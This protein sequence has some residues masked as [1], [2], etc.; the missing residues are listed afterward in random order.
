MN[1][2]LYKLLLYFNK[3]QYWRRIEQPKFAITTQLGSYFNMSFKDRLYDNHYDLF[4]EKGYPIRK[5]KKG[6]TVYNYTTLCSYALANWQEYLETGD[7]KFLN[8]L[9]LVVD[10]L[11]NNHETTDYGGVI[12]TMGGRT[13]AMS[14]GEALAVIA[15]AYE[16]RP[17]K[18]LIE[19]ARKIIRPFEVFVPDRGVKGYFK[20]VDT[21]WYEENTTLPYKHILNGMNYALMGLYDIYQVLPELQEAKELWEKGIESLQKALPLFDTGKWSHYWWD[22]SPTPHYIASAMYHNLHICQLRHLYSLSGIEQ[23]KIYADKF[24]SYQNSF[25]NRMNAGFKL[26][27]GKFRMR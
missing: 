3:N 12:F 19:F 11:K 8:P 9:F 24:E 23:F 18:E 26:V 15:R 10:Y 16:V 14:Q 13:C 6:E 21:I 7:K 25:L 4:D 27:S 20:E 17:D 1:H 2:N 5:N 22:E